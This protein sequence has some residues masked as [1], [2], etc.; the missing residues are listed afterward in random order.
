[1]QRGE[2]TRF[3]K[4]IGVTRQA[5]SQL[6]ADGVLSKSGDSRTWTVEY[7][8]HL[9]E[10]AAGRKAVDGE[11]FD[12]VR[13]RARL[14]ARQSE[15]LEIELEQLRGKLITESSVAEFF[16]AMLHAV[17][18]KLLAL[19][20][21][22]RSQFP[23]MPPRQVDALDNTVREILRE[24]SVERFPPTIRSSIEAYFERLRSG[25]EREKEGDCVAAVPPGGEKNIRRARTKR[26]KETSVKKT[27]NLPM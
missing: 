26:S 2:Q 6:I 12:L 21:R 5:V 4:S 15:K 8:E 23:Q 13:Q 14:A 7:C 22:H 11:E 17:R 10:I 20:S 19:P 9:R 16:N 24:L 1:M 3:A 27:E 18:A 25:V